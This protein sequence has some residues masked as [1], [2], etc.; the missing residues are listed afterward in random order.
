MA[1]RGN[2][3]L[4]RSHSTTLCYDN[5]EVGSLRNAKI[6]VFSF[7]AFVLL[8]DAATSLHGEDF[9]IPII[10]GCSEISAYTPEV[11]GLKPSIIFEH[12]HRIRFMN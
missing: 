5:R 11:T 2:S 8:S 12:V 6:V 9:T 7:A 4:E 10:L 3:F 1:Q